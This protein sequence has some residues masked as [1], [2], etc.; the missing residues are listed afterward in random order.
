MGVNPSDI[1]FF[2]DTQANIDAAT[3]LG[4]TAFHVNR[5]VGVIP[6]LKEL[7]LLPA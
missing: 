3:S 5:Q 2:D 4:M 6:L 1:W 7:N